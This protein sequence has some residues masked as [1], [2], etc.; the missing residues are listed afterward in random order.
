MGILLLKEESQEVI[1]CVGSADLAWD[2]V[3]R[4][5]TLASPMFLIC[6]LAAVRWPPS[7]EFPNLTGNSQ[8]PVNLPISCSP[9]I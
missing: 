7:E 8:R 9:R 5:L 4:T 3:C 1:E 6:E 2:S